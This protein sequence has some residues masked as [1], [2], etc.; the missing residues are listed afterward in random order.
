MFCNIT[1]STDQKKIAKKISRELLEKKY[2]P[3]VQITSPVESQYIWD[4]K[5]KSTEE[6]KIDIK[7]LNDLSEKVM[8][9]IKSIHNY[10]VPEI[11][12]NPITI[13]NKGYKNW[14]LEN[15]KK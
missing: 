4:G 15:T 1:T 5:I 8:I 11:I 7:T 2:S 6:Y 9:L 12:K 14:V 10:E 13:E 3:C